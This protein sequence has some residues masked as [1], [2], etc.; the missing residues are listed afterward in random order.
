[1]P[2]DEKPPEAPAA[3]KWEYRTE[4]RISKE[5]REI[6]LATIKVSQAQ[7]DLLKRKVE[8]LQYGS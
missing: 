8:K 3:P 4:M 5:M 6:V 1:M 2:D 7:I